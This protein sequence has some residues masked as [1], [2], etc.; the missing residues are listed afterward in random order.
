MAV[1]M[2]KIRFE[3]ARSFSENSSYGGKGKGAKMA[4]HQSVKSHELY[5]LKWYAYTILFSQIY[6]TKLNRDHD[7]RLKN[8]YKIDFYFGQPLNVCAQSNLFLS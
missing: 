6:Y 1:P 7:P 8:Q 4:N 5:Q 2:S 3:R